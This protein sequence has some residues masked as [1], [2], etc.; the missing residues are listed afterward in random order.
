MSKYFVSKYASL[1][2]YVPGEQ[3]QDKAY[4]KLNTNESPFEPPREIFDIVK[5][6]SRRLNLYSD[7]D[8]RVITQAIADYYG[9]EY[10][11]VLVTNGSDEALNYA[12]M[13][14]CD[15][16]HPIVFPNITYGFYPVIAN[17][18][19]IP[20]TEIA[21]N[22]DFTINSMDY[23]DIGKNI[24]IAN[25]NAPTGIAL[26]LSEIEAIITSNPDNIIIIDEAYIDF[27]GRSCIPLLRK[28]RNLL[29]TQTFSKSRSL[30]GARLG[31]ILGDAELIA[32]MNTLRNSCN[33]Y[34]VNRMT[35][36]AGVVALR[37]NTYF[38][39]NC[40]AI[41][42]NRRYTQKALEALGFRVLPSCANF[43]FVQSDRI[44]GEDLY[45]KLKDKGVLIRHFTKPEIADWNRIT[46]GSMRQMEILIEK[47]N[48]IF[49]EE[50][51]D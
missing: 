9:L 14:F 42:Y 16:D 43:I 51:K 6:Q 40:K 30:A 18:N 2:P 25:P 47:I 3:P 26:D 39:N 31:F 12:F 7:P 27:G 49:E 4:V 24:V 5:N 20:Y 37:E 38:M 15:E 45:L 33:P 29:V 41:M 46:I 11:N 10:E 32:D 1:S 8:N 44:S 19:G 34:N 28:Y 21:L 23:C 48:E 35:A 50:D 17:L 22:E 36:E 13:A